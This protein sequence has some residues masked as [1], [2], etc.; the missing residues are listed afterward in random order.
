MGRRL[1]CHAWVF[2]RRAELDGIQLHA[3]RSAQWCKQRGSREDGTTE[4]CTPPLCNTFRVE[5]INWDWLTRTGWFWTAAPAGS[6]HTGFIFASRPPNDGHT[7]EPM[8]C[9]ANGP[10]PSIR[11]NWLP[12]TIHSDGWVSLIPESICPVSFGT[13][14]CYGPGLIQGICITTG[15]GTNNRSVCRCWP[16]SGRPAGR[17][18]ARRWPVS[19]YD[20][21]LDP[22]ALMN[23]LP[24]WTMMIMNLDYYYPFVSCNTLQQQALFPQYVDRFFSSGGD[25]T[26]K[27]EKHTHTTHTRMHTRTRALNTPLTT[28]QKA[29][30]VSFHCLLCLCF[31]ILPL[32]LPLL[33]SAGHFVCFNFGLSSCCFYYYLWPSSDTRELKF[34]MYQ[35]KTH[36]H[37]K[38]KRRENSTVL[39]TKRLYSHAPHRARLCTSYNQQSIIKLSL[40]TTT[41]PLP[42]A[43]KWE[44]ITTIFSW[45]E[46]QAR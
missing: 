43:R 2:E 27:R 14:Y 4:V 46:H 32:L 34:K 15:T 11:R 22:D 3:Q 31:G 12:W 38:G 1:H 8:S 45:L 5:G 17:S 21:T 33:N 13:V 20:S 7:I 24:R 42:Q 16:S 30:R 10:R 25:S 41:Y 36:N 35:T 40:S 29:F 19:G 44:C 9:A 28:H 23:R 6:K 39:R 18:L 37:K 26:E